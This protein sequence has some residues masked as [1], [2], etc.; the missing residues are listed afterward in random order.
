MCCSRHASWLALALLACQSHDERA[1]SSPSEDSLVASVVAETSATPSDS[2]PRRDEGDAFV[3][4]KASM[5]WVVAPHRLLTERRLATARTLGSRGIETWT[6]KGTIAV[7]SAKPLRRQQHVACDSD[8]PLY[9][10]TG[11]GPSLEHAE[12]V[13]LIDSSDAAIGAGLVNVRPDSSWLSG[14]LTKLLAKRQDAAHR[15]TAFSAAAGDEFYSFHAMYDTS[16][17]A[18]EENGTHGVKYLVRRGLFLHTSNG[19]VIASEVSDVEAVECDGCGTPTISDNFGTV[20]DVIQVVRVPG[21]AHPV[22]FLDT[23]TVEGRALSLVMFD[24]AGAYRS[25]RLY[26]YVVNCF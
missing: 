23:G 13:L 24:A 5:A 2:Q 25:Y 7:D 6:Y 9:E 14:V 11:D 1:A 12:R 10:Y 17:A 18:D 21:L 16:A 26:E 8:G 20:F 19:A 22:L 3:G 4:L 15:D